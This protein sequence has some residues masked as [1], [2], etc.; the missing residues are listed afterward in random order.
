MQITAIVTRTG[1]RLTM[2]LALGLTL[3]L[4]AAN[5]AAAAG[6]TTPQDRARFVSVTRAL[7]TNPLDPGLQDDREWALRWLTEAPDVSVEICLDILG[8]AGRKSYPYAGEML[9]QYSFGM[10]AFVIEHPEAA[11]DKDAQQLAG[12]ESA[13]KA[14]SAIV[15]VRPDGRLKS[16]DA[17]LAAQSQGAL[18]EAVRKAAAK[19]KRR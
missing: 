3:L 14:Y 6:A 12:M 15:R 19:C 17:L 4:G 13:L 5:L 10:G 18:P 9:F 2:A 7:E 11:N 16:Y 1:R 8:D